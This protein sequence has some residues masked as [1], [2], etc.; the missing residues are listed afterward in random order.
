MLGARRWAQAGQAL[1]AQ[2]DAQG[3]R[4]VCRRECVGARAG[5]RCRQLGARARGAV[6]MQPCEAGGGRPA[7]R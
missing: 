4:R 2:L 7:G 5:R 1:G 6:G 3:A